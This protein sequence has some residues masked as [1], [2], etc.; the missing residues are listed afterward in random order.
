MLSVIIYLAVIL[1]FLVIGVR[2]YF[3]RSS[4]TSRISSVEEYNEQAK[5]LFNFV[6]QY[7]DRMEKLVAGMNHIFGEGW[8][9]KDEIE[10][11]HTQDRLLATLLII[12]MHNS[13]N[14]LPETVKEEETR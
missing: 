12:V 1:F 13:Y 9:T 10:S 5:T 6:N 3:I 4:G 8:V 11:T 2:L 14:S 7:E